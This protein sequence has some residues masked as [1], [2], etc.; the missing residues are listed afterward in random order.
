ME[1]RDVYLT[2]FL[3]ERLPKISY[4]V[5]YVGLLSCVFF[6]KANSKAFYFAY[7]VA[8]LTY[9]SFTLGGLFVVLISRLTRAGWNVVLRRISE[10]IMAN[11]WVM[12]LF[13]VPVLLGIH[14]LYIW[15]H[16]DVML[17]NPMLK[18]K[19][20]Y[21]NIP[22]FLVRAAVYFGVWFLLSRLF[23][24]YSVQQDTSG[25]PNLTL[26]LQKASTWGV[27][28]FALT[29]TFAAIDWAMSLAP[30]WYSTIFG[31]YFFAGCV[32]SGFAL[33]SLLALVLRRFGF[34]RSII[35]VE[36]YH[37]SAKLIFGF[38]VFWTYIAFSQ[39]FLIWYANLPEETHWYFERM[40]GNWA[41]VSTFLVIG[42][43]VLPLFVLMSKHVKRV[44]L[45]NGLM[46][47]WMLF[48][49]VVDIIWIVLPIAFP[50]GFHLP[51][52][53][54]PAFLGIGGIYF[55]VLF[56]RMRR[57]SLIPSKDPRFPE[58]LKFHTY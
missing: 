15:T 5:G 42:H 55:G 41:H 32:I 50:H 58:S 24:R 10:Q 23:F 20:P 22:F 56:S 47:A 53:F 33:T 21:L 8:F 31:V 34:L 18:S 19:M 7:L 9:L 14:D 54:I 6:W 30:L 12:A 16:S 25:D 11:V 36:H 40:H 26:K 1:V 38:V 27:L 43:F 17:A 35:T 3:A 13:F 29:L 37:D 57:Y 2:G 39:Y 45:L 52:A 44:L 46:C 48:M 4:F 49:Q 28:V 51:A